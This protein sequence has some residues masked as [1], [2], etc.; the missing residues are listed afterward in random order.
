MMYSGILDP[1]MVK[2]QY[3]S[4]T[5]AI[6]PPESLKILWLCVDIDTVS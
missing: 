2:R 1:V 5:Q 3:A 6:S 4:V